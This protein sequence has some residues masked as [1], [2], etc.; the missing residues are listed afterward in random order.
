MASARDMKMELELKPKKFGPGGFGWQKT[1]GITK[2]MVDDVPV[3]VRASC[4]AHV[5]GSKDGSFAVSESTFMK[6]AEALKAEFDV[7]PCEFS[8]G[9]FGWMA[10]RK[11]YV[12]VG[13]QSVQVQL[14]FNVP[15][16]NSKDAAVEEEDE[17]AEAISDT[18]ISKYFSVLGTA[19]SADRDDLTKI[20][21]IGPWIEARLNKIGIFKFHQIAKMTPEIEDAVN[22][23]IKYFKG[24]VRR[25]EWVLQARAIAGGSWA[26][27]NPIKGKAPGKVKIDG[28]EY[29]NKLIEIAD[30]AMSDGHIEHFEAE[31]LW[32]SASDGNKITPLEKKTLR[33]IMSSPK[34]KL[35]D[36]A[37][38]YLEA[39]ISALDARGVITH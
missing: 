20:R 24:R 17:V 6:T 14:N 13:G 33:Y 32:F 27:L 1:G 30:S 29:E 4:I 18:S 31:A 5:I 12:T 23:A 34:Y 25:D 21:G 35:D 9:S 26:Q 22:E 28:E 8:T 11:Q 16:N 10:H 39:K 3:F 2:V 37:E 15:I 36:E 38:N 19:T 7:E